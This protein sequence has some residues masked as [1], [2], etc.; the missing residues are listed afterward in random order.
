MTQTQSMM[1][2]FPIGIGCDLPEG[3]SGGPWIIDYVR[4]PSRTLN[5]FIYGLNA[6]FYLD[7]P[8]S[9][10]SPYFGNNFKN[11]YDDMVA[12]GA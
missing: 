2:Y 3:I 11:L 5:N 4:D 12:G 9:Q 8:K 1:E 7:K 6:Y 10:Y